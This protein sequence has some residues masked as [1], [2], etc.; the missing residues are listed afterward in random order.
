MIGVYICECGGNIGDVVDVNAVKEA[1]QKIPDVKTV[2]INRFLCSKLGLKMIIDSVKKQNLD[3]VV[4]ASCSPHM[5]EETFREAVVEAGLNPY[6]FVHTNIREQDSWVTKDKKKATQKA[7]AII[8]GAVGRARKLEPLQKTRVEISKDVLVVGGGIAGITA[9]LQLANSG[10]H[11]TLVEK[12]PSIGGKMAQLSKVFPTLDCAPCILSP[13]MADVDKSPNI[14]LLTNSVVEQVSGGPGNYEVKVRIKP[15]GVDVEKCLRCGKCEKVCEV[16]VPDEYEAG[17]YTRKAIH[18]PFA[19][20]VPAAYCID[21]ENCNRCGSCQEECPVEA[22]NINEEEREETYKV[23]A[24]IVTTGY[25]ILDKGEIERYKVDEESTITSLQLERLIENELA[26]GKVLKNSQGKRIKDVAFILCVGSRNPQKGVPYCSKVCC[27]YAVKE[28]ILLKKTLPYLRIWI[29]YID[30]RM[31]GRG[32][33]ELYRQAREMNINFIHGKPAE[34]SVDPDSGRLQIV[35]EDIDTGQIIK[36][37]LDLVVLC[38]AMIPTSDLADL[39]GRLNISVGEDGFI[40]EKHIKLNPVS[41]LREGIFAAGTALGPKDIRESVVDARSTVAQAIEFLGEGYKNISPIKAQLV[42]E[43]YGVGECVK[44]CPH[45]AITLNA[46]GKAQINI[47]ACNGC[48]A[49]VPACPHNALELAHYTKEQIL[50]EVKGLL[51]VPSEDIRIIGFFGDSTAYPAADTAGVSRLNYPPNLLI[52]RVPSTALLDTDT[53]IKTLE[54]GADGIMLC[55]NGDTREG[56]ITEENA[57]KAQVKLEEREIEKDRIF[58]QPLAIPAY[59][60]LPYLVETYLSR[61]KRIG[62]MGAKP[63]PLSKS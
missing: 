32:Y 27:P 15:R 41:T 60:S 52:V 19:Q 44:V 40:A 63:A 61:I 2:R 55:E 23:G 49:C 21:F 9:A 39:A 56:E 24:I 28:A 5:H 20:A 8:S 6:M 51:S 43:C 3:R 25:D 22:I 58:Y 10:Y 7:I 30:L 48:G 53:L 54:M 57:K 16:E 59:K 50:E 42:G 31:S 36:N 62:K 33:E 38:P 17:L 13:R 18:L 11:A 37:S 45:N 35:S 47:L 12:N 46:Q 26:A 14:T 4:V 29:Y 1:I 34:V